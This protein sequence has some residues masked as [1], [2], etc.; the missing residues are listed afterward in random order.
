MRFRLFSGSSEQV[1]GKKGQAK[2]IFSAKKAVKMGRNGLLHLSPVL[3]VRVD[4]GGQRKE[5]YCVC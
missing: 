2:R 4:G 1:S 3:L 5:Q